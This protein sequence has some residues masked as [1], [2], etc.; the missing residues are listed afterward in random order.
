MPENEAPSA[1][2]GLNAARMAAAA[3]ALGGAVLALAA[4]AWAVFR[5]VELS[6]SDRATTA[7]VMDTAARLL[8]G[9]GFG[10]LLW[11]GAWVLRRLDDVLE[12]VR[13]CANTSAGQN[14]DA[15][16]DEPQT[17]LLAE[18][19]GLTREV[20]DIAL[21]G[22][23]GRAARLQT[24]A[25]A[26][27]HQL[28]QEVGA[29]LRE[30]DWTEAARRVH[31]ARERF[32][33]LPDWS[34]FD[35]QIDQVRAAAEARDLEAATRDVTELVTLGAWDRAA[36]VVRHFQERHPECERAGELVRRVAAGREK[37]TA[38]ERARLMAQAQEATNRRDWIEALRVVESLLDRFPNSPEAHDLR[39]QLPTLR[40]NVEIQA[41]HQMELEIRDLIKDQRFA[42]ALRVARELLAR[43]PDSPQAGVLR[44]QL[45]R[46]EQRAAEQR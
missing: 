28:T 2:R 16:G 6:Q 42:D 4:L 24:E 23:Q 21:L 19:V 33:S 13:A 3:M 7:D 27:V 5:L 41:R 25:H 46:L 34:A 30:H 22:E 43:Y 36:E 12:A 11:G 9:C 17:R 37:A 10:V 20:R 26:L 39:P 15:A 35:A 1:A 38:E 45:P 32:P 31:R 29:L 44:D 8:L 40:T 18:L 14:A